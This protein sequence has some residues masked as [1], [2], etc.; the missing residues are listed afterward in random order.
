MKAH[1]LFRYLP[2]LAIAS[3]SADTFELK[4]GTTIEGTI[5]K[6]DGSDYIISVQVTKSIKDERRVPKADVV[7]QTAEQKD[8]TEFAELAKLV[9]T[10]DLQS[11]ETYQAQTIKVESFIKRHPQSPKKV[12]ALKL[13]SVLEKEFDVVTAGGVKFKGELI[14]ADERKP[15]A[16]ALDAGIQAATLKAAAERGEL[17]T[18]LRAWTKLETGYQG[19][20]AYRENIPYAVRVMRSHLSA[21][22]ASLAGF[23]AR[24]KSRA[25]GLSM[26]SGND[27]S[28]STAAIQEEQAAYTAL[29]EKDKAAGHKWPALDPYVKAPMEE[30]KRLLESEIRRLESVDTA[31]LPKSEQAYETAW[32]AVTKSGATAQEV[33]AALSAARSASLPQPYIDLLTKAAPAAPAN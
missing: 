13:L 26:M 30:T 9:P 33:S 3:V 18:A 19:S 7:K 27:R 32:A 12:E 25:D 5:V 23:D 8:E 6:E 24:A 1:R 4:D 16:Y 14:S 20:S 2:L 10:P 11:A 28:L 29:L 15:K 22:T 17:I 31:Q 21:V